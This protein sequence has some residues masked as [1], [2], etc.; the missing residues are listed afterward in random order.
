MQAVGAEIA[1]T[2]GEPPET[3][4]RLLKRAARAM[5][6]VAA[7]LMLG[8]LVAA[9]PGAT[10]APRRDIRWHGC[11]PQA[12]AT[13]QCGELA[14]PL[15]YRR[16]RGATI[17]LGFNRLRA[18]DRRRPI[19]SLIVNPGGPGGAGSDVV[20][21]EAAGGG[22][23]HPALHRRFDLI[24]MDPRGVGRSTRV[25][26]DPDAYNRPV[27]L[28]PRT[29]AQF[30]RLAR[31]ARRLG[32]SCRERTGPLLGHVDTLSVARDMEALRRALGDGK[33]NFLGLSYGAEI[34][35]LYAERYPKRI[36][37]MA[38]DGILDHSIAT[39]ALFADDAVA[40]EDTFNRFTAW[41]ARSADCAL[42]GRDVAALFDQL[43]QRADQ[44]PIPVPECATAPCRT[45]VTGGDIRLNAYDLLLVKSPIPA[46]GNRG[47][48]G[49]AEALAA[50]EAGD[51]SA[52]ARPLVTSPRDGTFAG[53]AVNCVDYPPLIRGFRDL[54]STTLLAR[55]LA[56]HTQGAGEAW[57][58]FVG[59]IHW[60][61]RLANPPHR[62]RI[63][64]APP[65][66][67]V[68]STHD[69]STPY[70]WAHDLL[71]QIPHAVLLTR[72]GDGHT[73]SFLRPS[74]TTNAIARYLITRKT[75]PP[76]TVYRD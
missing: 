11:G 74:R 4:E 46:L 61:A 75:P 36:R 26:C 71:R 55:S 24:G 54:V 41:C 22:L 21:V 20:A 38:L 58:G 44:H 2:A 16:P 12:P 45:P 35:T 6:V 56:P 52:F 3:L 64:G 30:R 42:H 73:S 50:L 53:L 7:L 76:N 23:W 29:A 25:R 32:R 5:I 10:A 34:G 31:Y 72:E 13:L 9:A 60:P 62:A 8:L 39:E 47:W 17:R 69:P 70:R 49:F 14:V 1:G 19:G 63:D 15:D 51:A 66:L 40:Y 67:L 65:I 43:V 48:N 18:Q 28:F 27:S 59:C 37:A 33:L 68:S 57:T